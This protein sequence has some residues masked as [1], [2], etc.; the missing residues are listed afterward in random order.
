MP[1][2]LKQTIWLSFS[3]KALPH[4]WRYERMQ[5]CIFY[6]QK[7][8]TQEN[9]E[10]CFDWFG[11]KKNYSKLFNQNYFLSQV[12]LCRQWLCLPKLSANDCF[13]EY[14]G[15]HQDTT[16]TRVHLMKKSSTYIFQILKH[17]RRCHGS[18]LFSSL[19]LGLVTVG[20]QRKIFFQKKNKTPQFLIAFNWFWCC[21]FRLCICISP[22][23]LIHNWAFAQQLSKSEP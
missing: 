5:N 7:L 2:G 3:P 1:S 22:I 11:E 18:F 4:I 15:S 9:P 12:G 16:R 10:A 13:H 20:Q 8:Y 23:W 14:G 21:S 6:E 19:R 17:K